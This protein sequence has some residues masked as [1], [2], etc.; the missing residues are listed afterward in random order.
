MGVRKRKPLFALDLALPLLL[1]LAGAELNA[2]ACAIPLEPR[3][4]LRVQ[5]IDGHFCLR[6]RVEVVGTRTLHRRLFELRV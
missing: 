6:V 4:L 3:K 2:W 5:L 1:V